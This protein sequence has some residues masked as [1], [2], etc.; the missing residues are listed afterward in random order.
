MTQRIPL[1]AMTSDTLDQLYARAEQAEAAL[2]QAELDAEQQERNFRTLMNERTS[3]RE[4]WKYEQKRRATAEAAI[5]RV[6]ALHKRF[7]D[8]SCFADGEDYP[9]PTLAALDGHPDPT[10]TR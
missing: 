3:Y 2:E 10:E 8:G 6:R 7:G 4:A 5:A 1:D 9:C